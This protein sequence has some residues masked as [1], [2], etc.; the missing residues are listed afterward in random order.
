M[1]LPW[2]ATSLPSTPWPG[3]QPSGDSISFPWHQH[4]TEVSAGCSRDAAITV[5][6][7]FVPH[8]SLAAHLKDGLGLS[9]RFLVLSAW[10][11]V[12]QKFSGMLAWHRKS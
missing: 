1:N 5:G 9:R 3:G 6:R 12:G 8:A 2:K 10:S 4:L 7:F 11:A